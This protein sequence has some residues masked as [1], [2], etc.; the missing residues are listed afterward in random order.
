MATAP[1]RRSLSAVVRVVTFGMV[2]A[3]LTLALIGY[4]A[5]RHVENR[6][7]SQEQRASN[8]SALVADV[9]SSLV[10]QEVGFRGYLATGSVTFLEPL[11][12]GEVVERSS[13]SGMWP[14]LEVLE[15]PSLRPLALRF[16]AAADD[17]HRGVVGPQ[18]DNR[19][20]GP[21][22][23]LSAALVAGKTSFDI[24]RRDHAVLM[25]AIRGSVEAA[26]TET[27]TLEAR[28]RIL[29]V[30]LMALVLALT[31]IGTRYLVRHTVRPLS[32]LAT[33]AEQHQGFSMPTDA[34]PIR[35]IHALASALSELDARVRD[36]ETQ[37]ATLHENAVELTKFGEYA[38]QLSDEHE[39]HDAFERVIHKVGTPTK[40]HVMVR[41]ASRNR[42]E[43]VRP[44]LTIEDQLRHPILGDPMKCR[45]ARTL[46]EVSA[47]HDAPIACRCEL[48]VPREGSYLCIPMLAA[49]ELVGITNLQSTERGHFSA[50]LSQRVQA[51]AG[52]AGATISS[53][54]LI[55][56]T[57]ERALR[58][59][60]TGVHNRA[61]LG[62]YLAKSIAAARRR[63]TPLAVIM[64]DLDHFK[65]INDHHGHLVGDQA[66]VALARCLQG[67]TRTS[68][69]VVRYGGE[70]F[71][72][73]LLDVDGPMAAQTAER[74]RAAIEATP[75]S[76]AGQD[77]GC[78]LR[79]SLGVAMFP[80]HGEDG[81]ALIAAAD[82]ALY[83]AKRAGRN[84]VELATIDRA[85]PTEG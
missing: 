27:A 38:Q 21:I 10:D 9:L 3:T 60:L 11:R 69:A 33:R 77:H 2:A 4:L 62:E 34:E 58:D 57:R 15:D 80:E 54:R 78:I 29:F 42:L 84:R 73:L 32:D 40:T 79:A 81:D 50:G 66:I 24:I 48:G 44:E 23:D 64:A 43:V 70:E 20:H 61:F 14:A 65:Q 59:G 67:A 6:R 28:L 35:E 49:G 68:D 18:L 22:E 63:S 75:V 51:Y 76:F 31:A 26:R 1:G 5:Q 36:R 25:L 74:I 82:A 55:A 45:A 72:V 85:R 46:R 13:R 56:A 37:L 17:W 16:V 12:S 83:R 30:V 47:E 71:V 8:A 7:A 52:F 41:N 19:A 53:M 39:L